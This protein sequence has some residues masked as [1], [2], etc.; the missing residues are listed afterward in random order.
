MAKKVIVVGAGLGGLS[1][2][3]RLVKKGFEVEIIEKNSK[4]GGRLN[5]IKK[6]GFTFDT[7]PSFFSMSYEFK[8]FAKECNIDIPFKYVELDPLYSVNFSGSPKTYHLYK[9]SS[10]LAEQFLE[11]EPAF[12]EKFEKYLRKSGKIFNDTV[13]IVIKNNFD[14][15]LAYFLTLARVNPTHIPV[16]FRSFWQQVKRHFNS[17][18]ARQ[19][20][21]LV[22]FFLGRTPFDTMAIYTLLSYTEFKHDGYYNVEGGMY[23]IVEGILSELNKENVKITYNTEIVAYESEKGKIKSVTDK[24]GHKYD[25]DIF[26]INADAA[27]FRST[28]LKRKKYSPEKLCKMNWTMGYLTFYVGISKKLPHV[29][30]HNYFLGTNY[31]E[32]ANKI[33]DNADTLQKPYYYVNLISKYNP[34]CA[35]EGCEALFFVC[36]VPNL[37]YKTDWSDKEIIVQSIIDDFSKRIGTDITGDIISKTIYTPQDWQDQFNLYKGS[38]LGLSHSMWQIGAFRPANFDEKFKNVFFVGASTIPG[39]GLPMAIISSK[40]AYERIIKIK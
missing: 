12:K 19:I 3:L 29:N 6:D 24:G 13:D 2:A 5:Q 21:S 36:P 1:T 22:A 39:A 14:S 37:M 20:I 7:G 31:E 26:L 8:L 15:K 17:K 28:V 23:G 18:E 30:H 40:L 34:D 9:D 11:E 38:G 35:P 25:A 10:K 16:L 32:Y 4:A 27:V 33:L